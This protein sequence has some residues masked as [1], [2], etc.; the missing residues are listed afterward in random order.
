MLFPSN[1]KESDDLISDI[2][3]CI[4]IIIIIIVII[5]IIIIII[6]Q[7]MFYNHLYQPSIQ[8]HT[9]QL[10]LLKTL[11]PPYCCFLVGN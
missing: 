4:I 11:K 1:G 3:T 2:S 8:Y 6:I 10:F 9:R 7:H 5:I